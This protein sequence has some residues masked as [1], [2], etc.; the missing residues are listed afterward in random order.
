MTKPVLV[1]GAGPVGLTMAAELARYRMPVRI[2]D[3]A[4]ERTDRSKALAVWSRT[5]ELLERAGCADAFASAG[6]HSQAM[7]LRSGSERIAR[8]PFNSVPS[9]F[10]YLLLI[11]QSETERLLD[12]HLRS[13]G[14]AIER[15]VELT[16]FEDRGEDVSCAVRHANGQVETIEASWLIGCDGAHSLVRHKLGMAFEGDTLATN[17]VLADVHVAGLDEPADALVSFLHEDG[18]VVF[19]PISPGRYRIIAE[20]ARKGTQG[21]G[22]EDIQ[23]IV[24]RRCPGRVA[25]SNPIWISD[26]GV[27][28][29]KVAN[30]RSG[31]VFVAGDAAHVHSPAGGQG[32]NTGMQD[33]FNLAWKLALTE[34]GLMR[35]DL[36]D[37]YSLERS[38]VA[39]QIL[40]DSGRMTRAVTLSNHVLQDIRNFVAHRILGFSDVQ[41]AF[42]DRLSEVTIAYPTSPLNT[43]SAGGLKGPA[44]GHRIIAERP[45]GAGDQPR[46][47]LMTAD[48][49]AARDFIQRHS[50]LIEADL[51]APPDPAGVWLVRPD[52]YVAAA[53]HAGDWGPIHDCLARLASCGSAKT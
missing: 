29:R 24:A 30:Y 1:A 2:I 40:Q 8:I 7:V 17:F 47:A 5:L 39:K 42:A 44:P 34:R 10:Q 46:F 32:M 53:A 21:P 20:A 27:N 22:L 12:E 4:P 6:L 50:T 51:R 52:G 36:L 19:F 13:F 45:F 11:P 33:A 18:P 23:A 31:R 28:E 26:F 15:S 3:Q 43:G 9:P 38:A 48:S 25:L 14:K 35:P 41:H 16:G 49:E 37:S